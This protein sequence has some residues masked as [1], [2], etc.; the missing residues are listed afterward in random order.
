M[1]IILILRSIRTFAIKN[2]SGP[3]YQGFCLRRTI[4]WLRSIIAWFYRIFHRNFILPNQTLLAHIIQ[5]LLIQFFLY[6]S[7]LREKGVH[8]LLE[9]LVVISLQQVYQF[10]GHNISETLWSFLCKLEVN[11]NSFPVY[12]AGS[13]LGTHV[14]DLPLICMDT[15][16]LF[17]F[18]LLYTSPSPR[19]CS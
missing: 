15:Y 2:L 1:Q 6:Y 5:H 16:N 17:T 18:C 3:S 8:I 9:L 14:F 4:G 19:D 13:P 12:I 10:M 7:P 11:P